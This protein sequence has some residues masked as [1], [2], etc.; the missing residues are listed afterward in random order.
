VFDAEKQRQ[1]LIDERYAQLR[2]L[3]TEEGLFR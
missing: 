2:I 1:L 3:K